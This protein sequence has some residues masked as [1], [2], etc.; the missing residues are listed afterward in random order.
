MALSME[1]QRILDEMARKLADEDPKLATRLAT[2]GR[3][4]FGGSFRSPRS[5]LAAAFLS[6][7]LIA[8][9]SLMMY[10]MIPFRAATNRHHPARPGATASATT[11]PGHSASGAGKSASQAGQSIQTGRAAASAPAP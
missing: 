9:V 5:R 11:Q 1:E 3:P 4:G 6:L 10:A 7:A 2:L 8:V